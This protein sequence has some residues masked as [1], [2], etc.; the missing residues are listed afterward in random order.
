M[1]SQRCDHASSLGSSRSG[2]SFRSARA[3]GVTVAA[4]PA[5]VS[6]SAIE[7]VAAPRRRPGELERDR[8][9]D[10]RGRRGAP[11]RPPPRRTPARRSRAAALID[12]DRRER[13]DP[14][15]GEMLLALLAP[16]EGHEPTRGW[17]TTSTAGLP[18][19]GMCVSQGAV[20][21]ERRRAWVDRPP[22]GPPLRQADRSRR[23]R[24]S[25]RGR[26]CSRHDSSRRSVGLGRSRPA[27]GPMI[28][29]TSAACR[30]L[31]CFR[32]AVRR[33]R[34]RRVGEVDVAGPEDPT[35]LTLRVVVADRRARDVEVAAGPD[36]APDVGNRRV[37]RDRRV[38]DGHVGLAGDG[39][40][41]IVGSIPVQRGPDDVT[42]PST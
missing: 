3:A 1:R 19:C 20:R 42:S 6:A 15:G 7:V 35:A 26:P 28:D 29:R 23:W 33:C 13:V 40:A 37:A 9:A 32:R 11:P 10:P 27:G 12:L 39:T 41:A 25:G 8:G 34:D 17:G 4:Q 36:S 14:L 24:R 18:G 38:D 22:P 16:T 30:P 5:P 21:A 2:S 31:R